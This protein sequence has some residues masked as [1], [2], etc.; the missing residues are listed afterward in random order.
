MQAARTLLASG[1]KALKAL[2]QAQ[3]PEPPPRIHNLARLT[4]AAGLLSTMPEAVLQTLV[5]VDPY[6][7]EARYPTTVTPEPPDPTLAAELVTR[8]EEALRWLLARL[9]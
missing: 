1:D 3:S 7:T 4:E 9:T 5:E 6:I 2:L 8:T